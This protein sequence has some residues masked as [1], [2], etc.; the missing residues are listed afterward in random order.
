MKKQENV[1]EI[2]TN[3]TPAPKKRK[4]L[5]RKWRYGAASTA[6]TVVVI[7]GVVLLNLVASVLEDRYPLNLDL[8]ANETYTLSQDC[9]DIAAAVDEDVEVVVFQDETYY[10]APNLGQEDLNTVARQFYEAMKQC[11]T[12][13]GGRIQTRY[14]NYADNPTLVAK[15]AEYDV[16]ENAILFLS[17]TRHSVTTLADMFTY[18][19]TT[20]Q[21]YGSLSVT[22]SLVEQKVATHLL[23]VTG[24]LSPVVVLTGHG[25]N[26]YTLQ[27]VTTVLENNAYDVETCDLTKSESINE[28]AI[29]LVIPA[30]TTDYSHDEV[31][32]IRDWL[33]QNGEYSRNVVLFTD[34]TAA[35]PNLYELVEEEYGLAVSREMIRE[36]KSY[37][38][39]PY[40]PYGDIAESD[41]VGDIAGSQV[42]SQFTQRILLTKE[43]NPELSLYNMPLISFGSSAQLAS[44]DDIQADTEKP[45]DADTYPLYGAAYAHKQVPS[46]TADMTVN[47]YAFV[48]GSPYFLDPSVLSYITA[49]E[50]EEL[51][52]RTFNATSGSENTV[53][54]SSRS[55]DTTVLAFA[56]S[57]QK[58]LGI[59]VFTVALPAATLLIG[60]IIFLKRR[61]L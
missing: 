55:V 10:R 30:P 14:I 24:N 6:L 28:D 2:M 3:K 46:P 25:E 22:E 45:Y 5:S 50:N 57:T 56:D 11:N 60:L 8:T 21:Y 44:L 40:A 4:K 39:T 51:F 13:S 17:A 29:T 58:W 20:L 59:G 61:H 41:L 38:S 52:V 31:V 26:S 37:L 27:N 23:K 19:E 53:T 35:C 7:V 15:Y 43:Q 16:D 33:Q 12:A 18:D 36:T 49:A 9:V 32:I 54:V 42:L 1:T 48:Y 34:Y 47:S